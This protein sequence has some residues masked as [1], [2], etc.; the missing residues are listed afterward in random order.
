MGQEARWW[1][2]RR[3]GE[4]SG[5]GI[6]VEV[7]LGDDEGT[8]FRRKKAEFEA[9]FGQVGGAG[10]ISNSKVRFFSGG[11]ALLPTAPPTACW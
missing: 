2:E 4:A 5:I 11:V 3:A 8:D 6:G 7:G 9:R 1:G 10:K